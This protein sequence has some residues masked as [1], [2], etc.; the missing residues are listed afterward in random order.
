MTVLIS[1]G[2]SG[3]DGGVE[4]VEETTVD[5]VE[6]DVQ[7]ESSVDDLRNVGGQRFWSSCSSLDGLDCRPVGGQP[8]YLKIRSGEEIRGLLRSASEALKCR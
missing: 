6:R 8:L 4:I 7:V 5:P 3:G 1:T 2:G